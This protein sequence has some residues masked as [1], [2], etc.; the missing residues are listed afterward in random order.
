MS[1]CLYCVLTSVFVS[2]VSH[3]QMTM[4]EKG[5]EVEDRE[6]KSHDLNSRSEDRNKLAFLVTDAP[7]WYLCIF[8]AIQVG[9]EPPALNL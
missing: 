2:D 5:I 4:A 6:Q 7:P 1:H 9:V 3:L 8:L